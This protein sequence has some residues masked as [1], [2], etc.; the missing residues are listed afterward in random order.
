MT[1]NF[2]ELRK[3]P[4][5]DVQF[6]R[7]IELEAISER[8]NEIVRQLKHA[9]SV[10]CYVF[11]MGAQSSATYNAIAKMDGVKL[12]HRSSVLPLKWRWLRWVVASEAGLIKIEQASVLKEVFEIVVDSA[13]AAIYILPL[14]AESD[15][16]ASVLRSVTPPDYSFGTSGLDD[17]FIYVV[18]ADNNESSTGAVEIV[19]YGTHAPVRL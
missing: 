3:G 11:G 17:Y 9:D 5:T 16:V 13:M 10:A 12:I 8:I 6:D 7:P 19:S 4:G 2:A 15:F 18:D 1:E 14:A